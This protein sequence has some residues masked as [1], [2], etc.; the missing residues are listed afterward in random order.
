MRI[1]H[2]APQNISN[3]PL[4][5][6]HA[7]RMLGYTSRLI[8]LAPHPFK[9]EEDICLNLPYLSS[10]IFQTFRKYWYYIRGCCGQQKYPSGHRNNSTLEKAWLRWRDSQ[11]ESRIERI[12][13]DLDLYSYDVFQLDG[14]LGLYRSGRFIQACKNLGKKVIVC[15]L[16]S[17]LRVR[18][19]IQPLD[20]IADLRCTVEFDHTALDPTLLYIGFPFNPEKMPESTSARYST[21]RIGHAPSKRE[22]KGTSEIL[23]ALQSL[24][25][26]YSFQIILIENIS[27]REALKMKSSCHIFIDQIS[28]IGFGINALE[29][30]AMGIPTC[31]SLVNGYS[32]FC[33]DNPFI[34]IT[35]S[36]IERELSLL[37]ESDSLRHKI[38][39][40]GL[41]WI[42]CNHNYID[43]VRA[44]H[45]KIDIR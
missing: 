15:Y 42:K 31:T 24:Q 8:T 21:L 19:P 9:F 29:A 28:E 14:G 4:T 3:V 26:Q 32:N 12:I 45:K 11:W 33:Q 20:A 22:A 36:N 13:E 44:I 16:G 37:I 39:E 25:S 6:V 27:Y 38:G 35:N 5:F 1:L 34:E 41:Q 10:D 7:E 17:D 30:V 2:I 43:I 18:G 23:R 40:K